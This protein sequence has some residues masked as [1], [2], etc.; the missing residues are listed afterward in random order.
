MFFSTFSF[1]LAT[2]KGQRDSLIIVLKGRAETEEQPRPAPWRWGIL[3][4]GPMIHTEMEVGKLRAAGGM[5][6]SEK[7]L[8]GERGVVTN[9]MPSFPAFAKAVWPFQE[10]KRQMFGLQHKEFCGALGCS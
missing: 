4:K 1:T 6:C 7:P 9:E 8:W 2:S 10:A 5:H 3:S